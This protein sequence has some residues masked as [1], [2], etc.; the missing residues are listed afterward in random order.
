MNTLKRLKD[1]ISSNINSVLDKAEDPEKMIDLSIRKI[2]EARCEIRKTIAEK[3]AERN[4]LASR[5]KAEKEAIGRWEIRSMLA[6]RKENDDLAREAIRE[7]QAMQKIAD[8]DISTKITIDNAI[9]SLTDTQHRLE[10]KLSEMKTKS[11]ELKTRAKSAK[12]RIKANDIIERKSGT[13]WLSKFE[14]LNKKIEK[15][16][17]EAALSAQ[18]VKTNH[19]FEEL[20]REEAIETEFRRIK[21]SFRK[22]E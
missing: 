6:A 20:E 16:E 11:E 8:D 5:I 21:E 13:E 10:E 2:E 4:L 14:E 22:E 17:A 15:W 7:K 18:S 1:I 3:E 12:E 9:S 19:S